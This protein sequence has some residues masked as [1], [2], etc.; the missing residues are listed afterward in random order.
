MRS[1]RSGQGPHL[2][3]LDHTQ[4]HLA[5]C[6]FQISDRYRNASFG[7]PL[8]ILD[9]PAGIFSRNCELRISLWLLIV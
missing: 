3:L 4:R 9:T 2:I 8:M 6:G 7:L 1:S 5:G